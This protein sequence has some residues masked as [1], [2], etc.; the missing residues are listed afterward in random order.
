M[1]HVLFCLEKAGCCIQVISR[2]KATYNLLADKE[3]MLVI[4]LFFLC[5]P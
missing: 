2:W 5:G 3:C 4:Y 1:F